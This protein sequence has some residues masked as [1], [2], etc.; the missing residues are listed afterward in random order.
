MFLFRRRTELVLLLIAFALYAVGDYTLR[1]QRGEEFDPLHPSLFAGFFLVAHFCLA[2]LRPRAD[3]IIL[4]VVALIAGVGL[5]FVY[6][7]EPDLVQAQL[8]WIGLGLILMI[9]VMGIVP[10]PMRLR[11]YKYVAATAGIILLAVTALFGTEVNGARLWLRIGG[12]NFQSTEVLKVLLIIFLAGYLSEKRELLSQTPI[13]WSRLRLPTL[14]YF[15]PLALIWA[16]T[17]VMLIWQKDLGAVA[18]LMA[19]T[20]VLLYVATGR[21]SFVLAGVALLIANIYLTYHAFNYVRDRVDV[22]LNPWADA[23]GSGYQIIQSTYALASGGILGAGIGHGY[24]T[25][26]PAVH[27]DFIFAAIGEEVGL[28]GAAALLALYLV[29]T[30]RGL[31]AALAQSVA[32]SQLLALG[33]SAILGIQTL[34]ILAGNLAIIPVTGVTLPFI[35]YGGSSIAVNFIIIGLLLQ[36]SVAGGLQSEA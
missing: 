13:T 28:V 36:M 2:I 30:F 27:T 20:L 16:L 3:E 25:Y 22:W 7:L 34:V 10:D 19:V 33:A 24:P 11:N 4:P 18:I 5:V 1:L 23:S 14:P 32:F 6:R 26:I 17:L 9:A 35:S 31:R 15:V 12:F 8:T 21:I 29:L